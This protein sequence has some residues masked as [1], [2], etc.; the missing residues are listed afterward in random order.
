MAIAE[1]GRAVEELRAGPTA[2][3]PGTFVLWELVLTPVIL[4]VACGTS[5]GAGSEVPPEV[6]L[7][8]RA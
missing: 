2:P 8:H 6:V 5:G 4:K 7:R 3:V 1:L